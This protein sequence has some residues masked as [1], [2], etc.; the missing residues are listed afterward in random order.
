MD[1]VSLINSHTFFLTSAVV[2]VCRF[3]VLDKKNESLQTK[4][5]SSK[6]ITKIKKLMGRVY[7]TS[8]GTLYLSFSDQP[9]KRP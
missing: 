7:R 4:T 3:D 1:L 2:A 5:L 6:N 9:S 8:S